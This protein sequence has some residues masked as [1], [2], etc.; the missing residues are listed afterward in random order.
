M[1]AICSAVSVHGLVHAQAASHG[2]RNHRRPADIR[3]ILN[4]IAG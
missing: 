1:Q 3:L 2:I 4:A